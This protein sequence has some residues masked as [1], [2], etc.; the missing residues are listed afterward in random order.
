MWFPQSVVKFVPRP[1]L[2]SVQAGHV[3][4]AASSKADNGELYDGAVFERPP[5]PS[6]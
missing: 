5:E 6:H 1:A 2:N 4:Q 3:P